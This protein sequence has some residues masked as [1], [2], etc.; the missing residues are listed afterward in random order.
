MLEQ[1]P[2]ST[3]DRDATLKPPQFRLRTLLL[4]TSVAAGMLAL[5]AAVGA[6]W[7]AAILF[8]GVLI[9]AHVIGNSLGTRLRDGAVTRPPARP[10]KASPTPRREYHAPSRLTQRARLHWITLVISLGGALAG[11]HFGGSALAASYPEAS[12]SAIVVGYASSGVLGGFAG[13]AVSSFVA[14]VRQALWEA[15]AGSDRPRRSN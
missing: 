15:H 1:P 12:T 14:V 8:F 5:F 10:V 13:F 6:I 2:E 11:A 4:A 3:K 7:T 9:S